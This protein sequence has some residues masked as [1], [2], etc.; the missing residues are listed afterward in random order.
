M[1]ESLA[2]ALFSPI[3][4]VGLN[5]AIHTST[6]N[7]TKWFPKSRRTKN[8]LQISVNW[9]NVKHIYNLLKI[10]GFAL[11]FRSLRS[12]EGYS[13]IISLAEVCHHQH[14]AYCC[15]LFLPHDFKLSIITQYCCITKL[16]DGGCLTGA[17]DM[18]LL[19][20]FDFQ[21]ANASTCQYSKQ[22]VKQ[23][24]NCLFS[25]DLCIK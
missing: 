7:N 5:W 23:F 10:C 13:F 4:S 22:T 2:S 12:N 20:L 9:K 18:L 15:C 6:V 17:E 21:P 3:T 25:V 24:Y 14:T 8:C 19:C 16:A 11:L 1:T